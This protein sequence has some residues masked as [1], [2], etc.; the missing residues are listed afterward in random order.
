MAKDVTVE[1]VVRKTYQVEVADHFDFEDDDALQALA[2]IAESDYDADTED[3][4]S[5]Y[6]TD[7]ETGTEYP[8]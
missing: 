5:V 7:D 3:W 1:I 8:A 4:E 6:I 2:Q